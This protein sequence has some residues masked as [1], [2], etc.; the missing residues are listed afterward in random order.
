V[1]V[2]M[3]VDKV[4]PTEK[5][6]EKAW[7][8]NHHGAGLAWREINQK[9]GKRVVR[10][11]KGIENVED[12]KKLMAEVPMTYIAHFRLASV[13]GGGVNP[14]LT[15]PFPIIKSAPLM[16]EGTIDGDV[17]FHNGN[18]KDWES[19]C[20]LAAIHSNTKVPGGKWSDTR[21]MAFL[22]AIFGPG[23]LE[24]LPKQKGILFGPN[25][26]YILTG[27]ENIKDKDH[28]WSE[29]EDGDVKIW[30]SNKLFWTKTQT[31]YTHTGNNYSQY[32]VHGSFAGSGK[33]WECYFPG[34]LR[35]D[36]D[37]QGY[38]P[39][40]KNGV[41]TETGGSQTPVI[42]FPVGEGQI[43]SLEMAIR[44]NAL[45]TRNL[46]GEKVISNNLL[47]KIRGLHLD[48]MS[49]SQKRVVVAGR[50]LKKITGKISMET[51]LRT[52]N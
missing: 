6:I 8:R 27:D 28:V 26:Y 22:S 51:A 52:V 3:I 21:G 23:Y 20:R 34:C 17:L 2:I 42:P 41:E 49:S 31:T 14:L 44:L 43:I 24:L 38:C 5:M 18:W 19:E 33:Q 37:A 13:D 25:S 39:R 32:P 11:K 35:R 45:G 30:C 29:V 46:K 47:K 10:W 48:L 4:R 40:H 15:H 12:M 1:C 7:E 50:E 9:T 36:T 16:K